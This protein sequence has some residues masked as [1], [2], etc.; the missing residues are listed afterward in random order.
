VALAKDLGES[1][2]KLSAAF[3]QRTIEESVSHV[4]PACF[5]RLKGV[6]VT[7]L[8][9]AP[10]K[11]QLLCRMIDQ[12]DTLDERATIKAFE[13]SHTP[14]I[15][16]HALKAFIVDD[17]LIRRVARVHGFTSTKQFERGAKIIGRTDRVRLRS[18][19]SQRWLA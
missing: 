10:C 19:A 15:K 6:D 11:G 2:L 9:S 1:C 3:L 5:I 14:E 12:Q 4:Q 8:E 17:P 16:L 18:Q 13:Y 7:V